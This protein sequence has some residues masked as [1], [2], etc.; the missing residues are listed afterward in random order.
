MGSG[1]E[2]KEYMILSYRRII[3]WTST[4]RETESLRSPRIWMEDGR[5][6]VRERSKGARW[7]ILRSVVRIR[8]V[9]SIT[10]LHGITTV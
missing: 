4:F 5:D 7:I 6:D 3:I 10:G 2:R 1:R 8:P 9:V